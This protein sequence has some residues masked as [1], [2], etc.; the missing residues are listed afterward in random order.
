MAVC[1]PQP[2]LKNSAGLGISYRYTD[3]I[4]GIFS[5]SDTSS[6]PAET[7]PNDRVR[8]AGLL[9]KPISI[10]VSPHSYL[11][12]LFI[13]TFLSAFLFYL[14]FD[15]AA[16]LIFGI[17]WLVVPILAF[18]DRIAFDGRRL[19]RTGLLPKVWASMNG[20]RK[21]LKLSDIE[22]VETQAVRTLKR[23]GNVYYRYRTSF[24]G[25]GV[26]F[27]AASGGEDYRRLI[28]AILP[29]LPENAL[30]NRS[31]EL[32]DYLSE[33]KD[34]LASAKFSHIPSA[35][36]LETSISEM[37]ARDKSMSVRTPDEIGKEDIEKA[38]G[39]RRLGN[40]LRLSGYLLQALEAFRRA[41][42]LNPWDARLLLEFA[43][44]L[45]SFAGAEHDPRLERKAIAVMRLAERRAGD[46]ENLLARLGE[47]YFQAGELRRA[48]LVFQ[49]AMD[50]VGESF[51][52]V[53]GMAELALR[54]G[55]I[56][57]VIHNFSTA[58]RLAETPALRRWTQGEADY[59]TR[60][61]DDDEYMELEVSRVNLLDNLESARKTSLRIAVLGFP[62]IVAG[63]ILEDDLLTNLGWAVSAVSLL[64]WTALLLGLRLLSTRIPF[65][66]ME[67]D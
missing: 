49:K 60:L 66:L 28:R 59:F 56:A 38:D 26:S 43:R 7:T 24:R 34:V 50:R 67:D 21:R 46:D 14:E 25:K 57:H 30:D 22:Q 47:S 63:L 61:N 51:R 45:Q 33:P 23:G 64:I 5:L 39:L 4:G 36:V 16:A 13:S 15:L 3:K 19:S 9:E 8:R 31:I 32:R 1:N 41:L 62:A 54:D 48:G 12:F 20:I 37:R 35:D 52:S 40:E 44:C 11:A 29:R 6:Q 55:K 42:L 18:T 17:S 65:E 2:E 58:N 53:R 10:R 27:T